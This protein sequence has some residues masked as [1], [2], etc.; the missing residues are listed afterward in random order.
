MWKRMEN[1]A[2][3]GGG[4][5][6]NPE[7]ETLLQKWNSPN[8]GNTYNGTADSDMTL[9]IFVN[10]DFNSY[11]DLTITLAGNVVYTKHFTDSAD[12]GLYYFRYDLKSGDS[13]KVY[14]SSN[15]EVYI[16]KKSS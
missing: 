14:A 16:M 4:A 3:G 2:S 15:K 9:S 5:F 8:S 12:K 6:E 13:I 11:G 1:G 10:M 7:R